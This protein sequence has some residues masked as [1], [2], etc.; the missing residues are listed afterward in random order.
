LCGISEYLRDL[1]D[2]ITAKELRAILEHAS[3][4]HINRDMIANCI[5]N[6]FRKEATKLLNRTVGQLVIALGNRPERLAEGTR[7]HAADQ[8]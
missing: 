1:R 5:D 4:I 3:A 2:T 8:C 6:F 7:T